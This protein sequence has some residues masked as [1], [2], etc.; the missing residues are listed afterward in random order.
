[1]ELNSSKFIANSSKT[2]RRGIWNVQNLFWVLNVQTF[3][4]SLYIQFTMKREI[5]FVEN[6]YPQY[7]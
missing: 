6:W 4:T 1:M 5:K 2:Y 7:L 3:F